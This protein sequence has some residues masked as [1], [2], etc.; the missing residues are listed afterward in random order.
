[1]RLH[2]AYVCYG[3]WSGSGVCNRIQ[4]SDQDRLLPKVNGDFLVQGY[5]CDKILYKNSITR[6]RIISRIVG[7]CP[8]L[9]YWIILDPIQRRVTSKI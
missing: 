5:I 6:S 9:Q 3:E 1:M 4:T 2:T 8:I 7:K